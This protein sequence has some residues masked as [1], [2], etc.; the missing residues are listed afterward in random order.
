MIKV[1]IPVFLFFGFIFFIVFRSSSP[2]MLNSLRDFVLIAASFIA[3][4]VYIELERR[5]W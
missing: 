1:F 3:A 4:S 5:G 2:D